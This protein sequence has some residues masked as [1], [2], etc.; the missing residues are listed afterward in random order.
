MPENMKDFIILCTNNKNEI[1]KLRILNM[2]DREELENMDWLRKK[3]HRI[4]VILLI[5]MIALGVICIIRGIQYIFTC[6]SQLEYKDTMLFGKYF[7]CGIAMVFFTIVGLLFFTYLLIIFM[8]IMEERIIK[9]EG[10]DYILQC[11]KEY[12]GDNWAILI[13]PVEKADSILNLLNART[14]TGTLLYKAPEARW[15]NITISYSREYFMLDWISYAENGDQLD[16]YE[17]FRVGNFI[18]NG[19]VEKDTIEFDFIKNELR[20]PLEFDLRESM[21]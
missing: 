1:V 15:T 20:V 18:K 5:I 9:K 12:S 3:T 17:V 21:K 11:M 8:Q 2:P 4:D 19:M 14:L 6:F 13:A 16:Q 7:E 10:C